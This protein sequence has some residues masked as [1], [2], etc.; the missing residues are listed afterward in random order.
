MKVLVFVRKLA[1]KKITQRD[2]QRLPRYS[3]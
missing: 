2:R 1:S 3:D